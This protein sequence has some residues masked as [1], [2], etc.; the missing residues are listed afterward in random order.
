MRK[1]RKEQVE[2]YCNLEGSRVSG[3][4][5]PPNILTTASKPDLI[6]VDR[7]ATPTRVALVELTVHWDSGAEGV[8]VRKEQR[9]ATL[10][11]DIREKGFQCH[12]TTLEIGARGLINPRN[13]SNIT[14]FCSLARERKVKRVT[15]IL[16]KLALLGSSCIWVARRSQ[17][18]TSGSLLKP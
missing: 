2:V 14:W 16:S 10:V 5:I 11:E 3:L 15:F 7:T 9:Y 12:H 4:T 13:K 17:D 6:L 8:R 1:I 18:W